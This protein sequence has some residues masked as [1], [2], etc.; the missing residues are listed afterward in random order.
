MEGVIA[1]GTAGISSKTTSSRSST[2]VSAISKRKQNEVAIN[3]GGVGQCYQEALAAA[4]S[5]RDRAPKRQLK[6]KSLMKLPE[7]KG[8]AMKITSTGNIKNS[9]NPNFVK[10]NFPPISNSPLDSPAVGVSPLTSESS[11]S[12]IETAISTLERAIRN[13]E[14]ALSPLQHLTSLLRGNIS[15]LLPTPTIVSSECCHRL[16]DVFKLRTSSPAE[17]QRGAVIGAV[18]HLFRNIDKDL[19]AYLKIPS[20]HDN[21]HRTKYQQKFNDLLTKHFGRNVPNFHANELIQT[22][23]STRDLRGLYEKLNGVKMP[24]PVG[25]ILMGVAMHGILQE[26]GGDKAL[27]EDVVQLP[28]LRREGQTGVRIVWHDY[29]DI[30]VPRIDLCDC[31][32]STSKPDNSMPSHN[33]SGDIGDSLNIFV[34]NHSGKIPSLQKTYVGDGS[35]FS[36]AYVDPYHQTLNVGIASAVVSGRRTSG[37]VNHE[38]EREWVQEVLR[39]DFVLGHSK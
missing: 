1:T 5:R 13:N 8:A 15:P 19:T 33:F 11:I 27:L 2:T 31:A 21:T 38:T 12:G 22:M 26:C 16:F 14:E 36:H 32:A 28:N 9:I 23:L 18:L 17:K 29:R 6:A 4:K 25:Q 35:C 10:Q 20:Y 30:Y 3:V 37:G 24:N 7:I 34:E 39:L